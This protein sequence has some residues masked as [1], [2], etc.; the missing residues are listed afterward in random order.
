MTVTDV[1]ALP[2]GLLTQDIQNGDATIHVRVGG[3]GPTVL[4]LHGF[5]ETGD[6][7]APLAA[8]LIG[9]HTFVAPDLRG[10]GLSSHPERGYDK[11]T[12]AGDIARALDV[13]KI[14]S[15]IW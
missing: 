10:M 8:T 7:W 14:D 1:H 3:S 6:M 4:M 12:Q 5:G 9:D 11:K 15:S 2:L 13:L